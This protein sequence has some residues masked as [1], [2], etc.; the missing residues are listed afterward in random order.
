MN[1]L[2]YATNKIRTASGL[3]IDPLNPDPDCINIDDIAHAL[4]NQC[5]FSGHTSRFFSVAEHCLNVASMLP[6][7]LKL[8]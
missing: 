3:Y 1:D 8:S 5:R 2:L 4:S 7:H 6:K